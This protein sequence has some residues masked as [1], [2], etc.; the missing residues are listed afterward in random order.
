MTD[1]SKTK[2]FF[3]FLL[4]LTGLAFGVDAMDKVSLSA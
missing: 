2:I 4:D 1:V 3:G